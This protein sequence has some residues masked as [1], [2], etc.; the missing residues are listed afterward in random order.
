MNDLKPVQFPGVTFVLG[1]PANW[2]EKMYG[3]CEGLPVKYDRE[4]LTYASCWTLTLRQRLALLFGRP[5]WL[6]LVGSAHPPVML[7][8]ETKVRP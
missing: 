8:V 1:A 6:H 7:T 2:D 4:A 5:L 3:Q